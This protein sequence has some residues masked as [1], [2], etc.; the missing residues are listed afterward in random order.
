MTIDEKKPRYRVIRDELRRDIANGQY[1]TGERLPSD[2]QL[3]ERF[4]TSR[5]TVIRALRDLESE[6]LVQRKAGSGTFV[7]PA[8]ASTARVFGILMPDLGDGEVFEPISQGIARA[9]ESSHQTVL[10]G[11][12]YP[13]GNSKEDYALELS[14]YFIQRK[15]SGVFFAPVELTPHQDDVNQR[16]AAELEGAGIHIVLL[17]RCIRPFPNRSRFDLVGIDNRRAGYRMAR[18]L[19]ERGAKRVAYVYRSGSAPTVSARLAGFREAVSEFSP[20]S[21]GLAFASDAS[22]IGAVARFMEQ[23]RPDG[24]VCANDLTAA[25]LMHHLLKLGVRVPEDVRMV[26]INDVKY[27]RFLPVPLTTLHQPCRE[28]GFG[29]MAAMLDRLERPE[30]PARDI[31]YDCELVVRQSCGSPEGAVE[32]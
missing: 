2:A 28:I 19:I 32:G 11:G 27:A 16:I 12:A 6:G 26:G 21:D 24:I 17:D 18:H 4:Q 5:L 13:T 10:W 25:K 8:A 3:A 30:T 23:C 14:Q 31:L 9:A 7:R 1:E 20:G 15:V 22:D 29:A